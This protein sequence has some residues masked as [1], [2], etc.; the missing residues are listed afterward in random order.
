MPPHPRRKAMEI[1]SSV[2]GSFGPTQSRSQ[3]DPFEER[4]WVGPLRRGAFEEF[5]ELAVMDRCPAI[6][7]A[8]RVSPNTAR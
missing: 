8:V 5:E 7:G 1:A 2:R 4:K 3:Q 6:R